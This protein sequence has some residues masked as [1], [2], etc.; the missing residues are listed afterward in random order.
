MY[1]YQP[2]VIKEPARLLVWQRVSVS[3]M[4]I[5]LN[6]TAI[7]WY[8]LSYSQRVHPGVTLAAFLCVSAAS[9]LFS[10][11]LR[12]TPLPRWGRRILFFVFAL[13]LLYAT[14]KILL[15]KNLAITGLDFLIR[16]INSFSFMTIDQAE[17]WHFVILSL[18]IWLSTMLSQ[19]PVNMERSLV[20]FQL[21]VFIFIMHALLT[22]GTTS[23][24]S[25][26]LFYLFLFFGLISLSTGRIASVGYERGG[27]LPRLNAFWLAGIPAAAAVFLLGALAAGWVS[28]TAL[29]PALRITAMVI[30]GLAI[31]LIALLT[32]PII[33]LIGAIV[34]DL[35]NLLRQFF[36]NVIDNSQIT[37][38]TQAVS[39]GSVTDNLF[40][41]INSGTAIGLGLLMIALVMLSLMN[42]HQ[43]NK[44][45]RRLSEE[46]EAPLRYYRDAGKEAKD[47]IPP[48]ASP[49][50]IQWLAAEKVRRIYIQLLNLCYRLDLKRE[51]SWTPQEFMIQIYT[52]FPEHVQSLKTITAAYEKVRYGRLIEN[53]EEIDEVQ[54]AWDQVRQAGNRLIAERKKLKQEIHYH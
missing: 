38:V 32:I 1:K 49:G 7:P 33:M 39:S 12:R 10:Q 43:K 53:R 28:T 47:G 27:R 30:L 37:A 3:S 23:V 44:S 19:N 20:L 2:P 42:L 6:L 22:L 31:F 8:L 34:P 9:Y 4:L 40:Q 18:I 13:G 36:K 14:Y 50:Y 35:L 51:E 5:A 45:A 52:L 54:A 15:L 25:K 26:G 21:C 24:T 29:S 11:Y 46:S 17:I 48:R 16:P 41:L